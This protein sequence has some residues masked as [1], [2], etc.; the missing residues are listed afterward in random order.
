MSDQDI[1]VKETK[2]KY[3]NTKGDLEKKRKQAIENLRKGREQRL[4][5]LKAQK[6]ESKYEIEDSASEDSDSSDDELLSSI[7]KPKTKKEAPKPPVYDNRLEKLENAVTEIIKIQKHH[8]K[9]MKRASKAK[10][11]KIVLLPPAAPASKPNKSGAD[12]LLEALK[13]GMW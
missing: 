8:L 6:H 9:K 11:E 1:E 10:S 2:P 12:A 3:K 5:N 13:G 7:M 4:K